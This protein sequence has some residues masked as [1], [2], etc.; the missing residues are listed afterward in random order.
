[1]SAAV[2]TRA[3]VVKESKPPKP[4]KV[5]SV[6]SLDIGPEELK[7]KQKADE[8][9]KK[10]WELVDEP[11]VKMMSVDEMTDQGELLTGQC[12]IWNVCVD[13]TCI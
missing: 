10:Y 2:Q 9:L 13:R 3:M 1:M 12:P 8:S 7:M 6:P 4:L 5:K 11:T